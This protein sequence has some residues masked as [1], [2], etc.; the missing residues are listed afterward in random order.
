MPEPVD[1]PAVIEIL[2]SLRRVHTRLDEIGE[3]RGELQRQIGICEVCRTK[4]DRCVAELHGNGREGLVSIQAKHDQ[5][6]MQIERQVRRLGVPARS[7]KRSHRSS[8]AAVIVAVLTA[9]TSLMSWLASSTRAIAILLLLLLTATP[10][11]A[12]FPGSGIIGGG[13]GNLPAKLQPALWLDASDGYCWQD[14]AAGFVAADK[15]WLKIADASQTGLDIGTDDC[16]V[17]VYVYSTSLSNSQCLFS[18]GANGATGSFSAGYAL[19]ANA[20]G[21]L[22]LYYGD[23]TGSRLSAT[24]TAGVIITNTWCHVALAFDRSGSANVYKDGN[25]T[26]VLT[27]DISPQ[28]GEINS[29]QPFMAG[30]FP[31]P[32]WHFDGRLDSLMFFKAADLSGVASD[33]IAWAYNDGAGRLGED[34][35]LTAAAAAGWGPVS[36]WDFNGSP[37]VDSWG[38]N[39]LTFSASPIISPTVYGSELLTNGNLDSWA[40]DTNLNNWYEDNLGTGA[41]AR[42]AT[43]VHTAAGNALK[44]T[45]GDNA[46]I[47]EYFDTATLAAGAY[48]L[49][50]WTHGDSTN[51]SRYRVYGSSSGDIVGVANSNVTGT[52]YT[53]VTVDFTNPQSQVIEI[54]LYGNATSGA[55][56]YFDDISLKAITTAAV[57]NGGFESWTVPSAA[58]LVANG[59]FT[60]GISGWT[61]NETYPWDTFEA[62]AG[63]TLHVAC[64]GTAPP[65][66]CIAYSTAF[67][68]TSGAVY[69]IRYTPTRTSGN[70][71]VAV[72]GGVDGSP[73]LGYNVTHSSTPAAPIDTY[74]IATGT[75]ATAYLQFTAV[76]T[77]PADWTIDS[78]SIQQVPSNAD[79]W[80]ES[81]SGSSLIYREDAA[82]YSGSH[83]LALQVDSAD[84]GVSVYSGTGTAGK[85]YSYTVYAKASSVTGETPAL[86]AGGITGNAHPLTTEYAAYTG[87]T[88]YVSNYILL[89]GR[90]G[91]TCTSKSIFIDSVTLTAAE[92]LPVAGIVRGR[93]QDSN[94]AASLVGTQCFN[95]AGT[96]FNPGTGDFS[97]FGAF[98]LNSLPAG[99]N[100]ATIFSGGTISASGTDYIWLFVNPTGAVRVDFN[101]GG[102]RATATSTLTVQPGQWYAITA[103]FDRDGLVVVKVN[104]V[105]YIS[106]SISAN[107]GNCSPGLLTV[108]RYSDGAFY[109]LGGIIDNCGY[110]D[111]LM[112]AAETTYLYND[113]AWRQWAEIE[114]DQPALAEDIVAMWEFDDKASLGDDSGPSNLDLTPQGTPTQTTGI[115]YTEGQVSYW[116]DRSGNGRHAYSTT[117]AQYPAFCSEVA[118]IGGRNLVRFDGVDDF[119]SLPTISSTASDYTI[120]VVVDPYVATGTYQYILGRADLYAVHL[121]DTSGKTGVYNNS[122]FTVAG[123]ATADPQILCYSL[124]STGTAGQVFR[125]GTQLGSDFAY[126]ATT[127][128]STPKIGAN[129]AGNSAFY[130]GDIAAVLV[131]NKVLS[132]AERATVTAWLQSVYQL[133]P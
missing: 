109:Y 126:V 116:M 114:A 5:K 97:L 4:I 30:V 67:S 83:A 7:I 75:D 61:K 39:D 65:S 101:D 41:I 13:N 124:N 64:D 115:N 129:G 37:W 92:I 80:T 20:N 127:L 32:L 44:I 77:A 113:G 23:G 42:E 125:D 71:S 119:L 16:I 58:E 62:G 28:A 22:T 117:L 104:D 79:S 15:S 60:G 87:T 128:D 86:F 27:L 29:S 123:N 106:T 107:N 85:L 52:N 57:N 63:D 54:F 1:S 122:A 93:S 59:N 19:V 131:Y 14:A 88:R 48:R 96:A 18:K 72:A 102:T 121:T 45:T 26:P 73:N 68:V 49:S 76:N 9:I 89:L 35:D 36:C 55:V 99:S 66:V 47:R 94:F 133:S 70:L 17:S 38:S 74:F 51:G 69:R 3:L 82:P 53:L 84:S 46:N 91:A 24:S 31:G 118:A 40:S 100:Y 11:P 34:L 78:V 105:T 50:F 25:T 8:L 111:R 132:S 98:Y 33:I 43:D 110:V 90:S 81:V 56:V 103:T 6:L 12:Q 108:G 112:T 120:F 130:N 95:Y 2:A 10:A 21:S